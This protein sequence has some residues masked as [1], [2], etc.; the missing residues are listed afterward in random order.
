MTH[1]NAI[2]RKEYN[3]QNQ[4]AL[5]MSPYQCAEWA[6]FLQWRGL[7]FSVMKGQ[8]GT[9]I[10]KLVTYTDKNGKEQHA[11]RTYTVFNREQVEA[12]TK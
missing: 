11:P 4:T 9:R 8:K 1:I 12:I 10:I 7:G 3:G 6:T 2:T 5:S